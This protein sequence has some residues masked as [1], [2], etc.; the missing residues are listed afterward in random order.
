MC[1]VR[2]GPRGNRLP[3]SDCTHGGNLLRYFCLL[4]A[5][6]IALH[7]PAGLAAVCISDAQVMP[8]MT[9][10]A[11]SAQILGRWQ[12]SYDTLNKHATVVAMMP[13]D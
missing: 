8:V 3:G 2:S 1:A 5:H 4:P 9:A 13:D 6:H 12:V 11:A 10:L 7:D